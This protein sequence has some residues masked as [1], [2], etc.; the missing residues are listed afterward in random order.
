MTE[1]LRS[2]PH[3]NPIR[4]VGKQVGAQPAKQRIEQGESQHAD[5]HHVQCRESFVHKDLVDDHLGKERGQ[6]RK[7][8]EEERRRYLSTAGIN[9]VMSKERSSIRKPARFVQSSRLP[10]HVATNSSF[11]R[12]FGRFSSGS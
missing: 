5:S 2:Q 1:Q 8:L 4:G 9:Q 10:L 6:Q 7:E 12:R 11:M 3:I